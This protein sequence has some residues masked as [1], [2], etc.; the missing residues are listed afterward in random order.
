M[1][2]KQLAEAAKAR[3]EQCT[4]MLKAHEI[5][6]KDIWDAQPNPFLKIKEHTSEHQINMRALIINPWIEARKEY[7]TALK[8]L[9]GNQ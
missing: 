1:N 6:W 3:Y 8:A 4:R 5:L 2:K 7:E 9:R